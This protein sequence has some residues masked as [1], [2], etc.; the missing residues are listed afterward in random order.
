[1]MAHPATEVSGTASLESARRPHTVWATDNNPDVRIEQLSE[2]STESMRLCRVRASF[3]TRHPTDLIDI[4]DLVADLCRKHAAEVGQAL[5]FCRHTTCGLLLNEH[6][7]G[8]HE[9]LLDLLE[10][11]ASP[12][13]YWAHDDLSRR[14]ENLNPDER[15]N[16][17][18][19]VRASLV[20]HPFM[21]IPIEDG[22]LGLGTWQRLLFLELDGPR[23]RSITVQFV[24][25]SRGDSGAVVLAQ[26]EPDE[27][28]GSEE[29]TIDRSSLHGNGATA[30]QAEL[31][32]AAAK[33]P[34]TTASVDASVPVGTASEWIEGLRTKLGIPALRDDW[35]RLNLELQKATQSEDRFMAAIASH[36][37][38]AGGKRVRPLLSL[39]VGHVADGGDAPIPDRVLQ[40]AVMVELLHL[41]TLY[42]DDVM[43]EAATRRGVAS[44]NDTWGNRAAIMAGDFLL[45]QAANISGFLGATEAKLLAATLKDLCEGQALELQ[46]FYN[47]ARTLAEYVQ[48]IAG[49]TASLI[50]LSCH[51]GALESGLSAASVEAFSRFGHHVGM[52]FQIIDD[53]LDLTGS[54]HSLG[55]PAGHDL[56]EG[57][58]TYPVIDALRTSEELR[59]LLVSAPRVED[60]PQVRELV[61]EHGG[62]DRALTVAQRHVDKA[63]ALLQSQQDLSE[64]L[65]SA[66]QMLVEE[67]LQRKV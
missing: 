10:E 41:G 35:G 39:I 12:D 54:D 36:L 64:R 50:S 52:A 22:S 51:I 5:I 26:L 4:T 45:G 66:L 46:S 37:T 44:A 6:E 42:H 17:H 48:C 13:K 59:S 47:P 34:T 32:D 27:Y 33:L 14:W 40:G 20:T 63:L 61:Q 56:L 58:Y 25:F 31:V 24:G 8:F 2:A 28:D 3:S 67:L 49:K 21:D 38:K 16:G 29:I 18:S 19:H 23:E 43:D 55:K 30:Q 9:D 57:V 62:I 1:M 53:V 7:S 65:L 15:P 11:H 60:I